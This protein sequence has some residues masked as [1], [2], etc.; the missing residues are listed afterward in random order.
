M[1]TPVTRAASRGSR[2]GSAGVSGPRGWVRSIRCCSTL[3]ATRSARRS[4]GGGLRR[5]AY[6]KRLP[7]PSGRARDDGVTRRAPRLA[8]RRTWQGGVS[9]RPELSAA[10]DRERS[11]ADARGVPLSPVAGREE[12]LPH[13][14]LRAGP[15]SEPAVHIALRPP[16]LA[17]RNRAGDGGRV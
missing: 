13:R 5:C 2:I 9:R 3:L 8:R 1:P 10:R 16:V 6:W 17:A 11:R 12:G 4:N 15:V 14:G 7:P